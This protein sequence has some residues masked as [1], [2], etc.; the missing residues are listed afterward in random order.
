MASVPRTLSTAPKAKPKT[1]SR[2]TQA[3]ART[4]PGR[5]E[6]PVL[7][8]PDY[9]RL[10]HDADDLTARVWVVT[11]EMAKIIMDM[12]EDAVAKREA[13]GEEI[14]GK[15]RIQRPTQSARYG[16]DMRDGKWHGRNGETVKI[17][18]EYLV[19]DGQHRFKELIKQD[20]PVELML[21][22]GAK[23]EER[24]T[25]DRNI[26]RLLSDSMGLSGFPDG[27]SLAEIVLWVYRM[28]H[29]GNVLGRNGNRPS[30]EVLMEWARVRRDTLGP[31]AAY[32]AM[33]YRRYSKVT[34]RV[35][36]MAHYLLHK[37]DPVKAEVFLT[38]LATCVDVPGD[39]VI[40]TLRD[41]LD[42][43]T[44]REGEKMTSED[45]LCLIMM[46]WNVYMGHGGS[47]KLQLPKEG[48]TGANFR[49]PVNGAGK[50]QVLVTPDKS[51]TRA[52]A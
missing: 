28:E 3:P 6:A 37:I 41:R 26:A 14:T 11:P 23:L 16:D 51:P 13:A 4:E 20:K 45:R 42:R 15:N 38:G 17:T 32:A 52:R 29:D 2:S 5:K 36:G 48:L 46:A 35:Y 18:Y 31:A 34:P 47:R 33:A 22:F 40:H 27:K 10:V 25:V 21:Y 30:D 8:E 12:H 43:G 44:K 24:H 39:S 7:T 49:W 1:G 19:T 9:H 50:P